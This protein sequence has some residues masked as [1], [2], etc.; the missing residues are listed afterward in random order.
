[1]CEPC[2]G[3]EAP[4]VM[5][6]NS[7]DEWHTWLFWVFTSVQKVFFKD[8]NGITGNWALRRILMREGIY[9]CKYQKIQH[10]C[11]GPH[12]GSRYVTQLYAT[13][14]N[15]PVPEIRPKTISCS[16]TC[17]HGSLSNQTATLT[18]D[19]VIK[20]HSHLLFFR[21]RCGSQQA[22]RPTTCQRPGIDS[23]SPTLFVHSSLHPTVC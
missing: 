20:D 9:V 8:L 13:T 17:K 3:R 14:P 5:Y 21:K 1:M 6:G 18:R 2:A 19:F 7:E 22:A 4:L 23:S 11:H 12:G 16:R 15:V 10:G